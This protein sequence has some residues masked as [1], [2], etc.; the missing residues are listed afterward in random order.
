VFALKRPNESAY[1]LFWQHADGTGDVQR[2]TESSNI[3]WP[4]SWHPSS[5]F[6]AFQE[7]RQRTGTDLMILPMAGGES[8]SWTPGTPT[9]F[10]S[11]P[12]FN[13]R[14]PMFSP[15]GR[16]IA[17][18]SDET[19]RD[20]V[21]V[22]PF[23]GPGGKWQISPNGGNTPTWSRTRRELF[24]RGADNR[25]NVASYVVDG[26]SFRADKPRVWSERP[27]SLRPHQRVYDLHPDGDRVANAVFK[28]VSQMN[29]DKVVVF[30][31]FSDELRRIASVN[32]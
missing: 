24:Y 4:G 30:F 5:K 22:R 19:G 29:Q 23:P 1:N 13:E 27:L 20:E 10:L 21:F 26:D 15:D 12:P 11:T 6:L 18:Q 9:V 7:D 17:Y 8:S 32:K 3:Q 31:N 28:D 2:L 16:W 14:E 25:L